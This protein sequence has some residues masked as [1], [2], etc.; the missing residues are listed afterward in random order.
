MERY[1][2]MKED[3]VL[4]IIDIQDKLMTAMDQRE[5]VYKNTKLMLSVAK[6]FD[7]PVVV[8]EQYPRGLG[9]TVP[10][11]AS[12]LPASCGMVDKKTFDAC[13]SGLA[14]TLAE[15]GRKQVIVC[16]TET[17]V[18]VFQTTR[19]ML[20]LGYKVFVVRDAV[21]SRTDENY[22]SGLQLMTEM[23]AV[24][25]S[26]EGIAFDFLQASGTPAFKAISAQLK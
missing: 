25:I 17:H 15:T 6:E 1:K 13:K 24:V 18:C 20:E 4:L 21:C 23:G 12:E 11:I 19:S 10:E 9:S 22:Q 3:A 8:T 7:L 14:E 26:A 2:L 5:K 16:G